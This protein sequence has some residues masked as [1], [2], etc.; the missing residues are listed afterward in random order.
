MVLPQPNINI[1]LNQAQFGTIM[2]GF[3]N[4]SY[5]G[6]M[7]QRWSEIKKLHNTSMAFAS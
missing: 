3:Q 5:I 1:T 4:L 6:E 7:R 2:Q